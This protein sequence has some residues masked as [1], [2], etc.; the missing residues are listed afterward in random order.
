VIETRSNPSQRW[1][2]V[3]GGMLGLALAKRLAE[4]GQQVTV[5]EGASEV[6]AELPGTAT[7][8]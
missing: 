5:L 4:H 7:I 3:G 2:V 6:G 1:A 8:T